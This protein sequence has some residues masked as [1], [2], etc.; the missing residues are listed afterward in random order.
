ME[1]VPEVPATASPGDDEAPAARRLASIRR[2][3]AMRTSRPART[4]S[5]PSSPAIR[6]VLAGDGSTVS[7][8]LRAAKISWVRFS[9][10]SRSA[11]ASISSERMRLGSPVRTQS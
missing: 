3:S 10:T 11:F 9:P 5:A 8:S 2:R 4:F 6:S 7:G 1:V